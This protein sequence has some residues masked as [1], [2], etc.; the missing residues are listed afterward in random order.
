MQLEYITLVVFEIDCAFGLRAPLD[1]RVIGPEQ[2]VQFRGE[3]LFPGPAIG[4]VAAA[5]LQAE[6][7]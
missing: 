2:F 4:R 6:G 3:G 7:A 1:R 5:A